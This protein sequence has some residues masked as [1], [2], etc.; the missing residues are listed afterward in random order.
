M[1]FLTPTGG[2]SGYGTLVSPQHKGIPINIKNGMP[3]GAD[4]GCLDGPSFVKKMDFNKSVELLESLIPYKNNCLFVAGFD[5]VYSA[6][7]TLDAYAEFKH[8]FKGWPIAYVAQN[9][10]ESLPIPETA[11]AVFIG[12]LKTTD[13]VNGKQAEWKESAAAV[14]IIKRAQASGL[15]VHIGRVNTMRR[16]RIFRVLEGSDKFTCDGTKSRYVGVKKAHMLYKRLE[17]QPPLFQI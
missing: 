8:Y 17:L 6:K 3:W 12:G 14:S 15:H 11:A 13:M 9:G 10:S 16:Y 7:D 5:V 2:L 1:K 4:L